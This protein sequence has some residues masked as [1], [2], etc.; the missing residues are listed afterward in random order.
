MSATRR[1]PTLD[2]D[3]LIDPNVLFAPESQVRCQLLLLPLV[4]VRLLNF[5]PEK[6][7]MNH[8]GVVGRFK[9]R[10]ISSSCLL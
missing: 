3:L 9:A 8:A 5:F 1:S 10:T 4:P 6:T 7:A 2:V